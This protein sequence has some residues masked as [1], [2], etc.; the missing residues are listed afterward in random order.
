MIFVYG[1]LKVDGRL[2]KSFDEQRIK[3]IPGIVH[4]F[5]MHSFHSFPGVVQDPRYKIK[6]ELHLYND[7]VDVLT[8]M[9]QIEGYDVL[10]PKRSMYIRELVTVKTNSRFDSCPAYMY[11]WNGNLAG[12]S[13]IENGEWI[14]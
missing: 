12:K 2:A 8:R 13:I 6:G 11:V 1:T 7:I 3:S 9:D 5:R 10:K 4:G 14:N